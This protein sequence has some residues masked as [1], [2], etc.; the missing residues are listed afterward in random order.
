MNRGSAPVGRGQAD[1]HRAQDGEHVGLQERHQHLERVHGEQE[2][3]PGDGDGPHRN[4]R[5]LDG[6]ADEHAGEQ[7]EDAE[8]HVAC[9][10]VAVESHGQREHAQHRGEE[11]EEPHD[12]HHDHGQ[13]GRRERLEVAAQALDLDAVEDEVD[14]RDGG[15]GPRDGD[16]PG[17]RLAA[18]DEAHEVA[19][20]DEEE[21]RGQERDVLL[22]AVAD[23]ALSHVLLHELVAVLDHVRELVRGDEREALPRRQHDDERDDEADDHPQHVL[24]HAERARAEHKDRV[25][26]MLQ[27]GHLGR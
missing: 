15:E 3:H 25:E 12:G 2:Q 24:G 22:V 26:R 20:E 18:G 23:G 8:H 27:M 1:V 16:G 14:E 11:L 9:E 19:D 21:Q 10:H 4:A 5:A 17:G 7:G 13:A 6:G